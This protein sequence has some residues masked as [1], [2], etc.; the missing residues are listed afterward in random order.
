M[1]DAADLLRRCGLKEPQ[2][3]DYTA[4]VFSVE[5]AGGLGKGR[6][7]ACGSLKGEMIQA[8]AVDSAFQ[9]EDLTG[10][11]LTHLIG[12]ARERGRSN[13]YLFT[14]P[15]KVYQFQG[16]GFQLVAAARPYAA[17]LEWGGGVKAYMKQLAAVRAEA[18]G[19]CDDEAAGA[20]ALVMNCNPFTRGHR[21]LIEYAAA[22][23]KHVF[24]LA[25]EEEASLFSFA[26][27]LEMLKRGTA[28]LSNVTVIPGGRYAVSSLTFPSY[29][30]KEE[31]LAKAHA[32]MDGE[33]FAA[34]IAPALGTDERFLGTEPASAVTAVYNETLK[35]RLPK[36][37]IKVTEIPRLEASGKVISAS[38]VREILHHIRQEKGTVSG[39]AGD[40]GFAELAELLPESTLSYI[41]RPATLQRLDEDF[42]EREAGADG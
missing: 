22:R 37:G 3:V 17:L 39:L 16:L 7:A 19:H 34:C 31:N 40:L 23:K 41:C 14:K 5:E 2:C 38:R 26:D 32:A 27:R 8:V 18:L 12:A 9:G 15:E 42:A 25:V 36:R 11:L 20:G 24:V 1:K 10:R 28:D 6:L 4:G 33:I 13:L 29:F 21:H 30:T 35:D